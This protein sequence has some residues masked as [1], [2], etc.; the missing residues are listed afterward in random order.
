MEQSLDFSIQTLLD[1][2]LR[3]KQETTEHYRATIL[4]AEHTAKFVTSATLVDVATQGQQ[5]RE[6]DLKHS[7]D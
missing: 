2:E 6:A 5:H 3:A 4:H 1:I 7:L